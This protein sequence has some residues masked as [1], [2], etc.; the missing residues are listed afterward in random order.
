MQK[1][2]SN[3]FTG[4]SCILVTL[5]PNTKSVFLALLM[6]RER[7]YAAGGSR[8]LGRLH[9]HVALVVCAKVLMTLFVN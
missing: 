1:C 7:G 9:T 4:P 2:I 6:L 8:V 3:K 5:S